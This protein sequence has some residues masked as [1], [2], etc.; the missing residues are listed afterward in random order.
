MCPLYRSA[1]SLS[2]CSRQNDHFCFLAFNSLQLLSMLFPTSLP[3]S[4]FVPLK[5]NVP[6]TCSSVAQPEV[7]ESFPV[8][9]H[10]CVGYLVRHPTEAGCNATGHVQQFQI[11]R[12]T[13]TNK[14]TKFLHIHKSQPLTP[15]GHS[16]N[17]HLSVPSFK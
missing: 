9:N 10:L 3:M 11:G 14:S 2:V 6:N 8:A 5:L 17:S 15:F 12:C 4:F 7:D 16:K 13:K 1:Y